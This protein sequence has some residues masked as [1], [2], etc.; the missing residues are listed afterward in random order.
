MASIVCGTDFS[1]QSMTAATVAATH[2]AALNRHPL[3]VIPAGRE[4]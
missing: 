1:D 2:R 4:A 3:L